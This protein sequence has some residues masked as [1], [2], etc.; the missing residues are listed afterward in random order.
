VIY[1]VSGIDTGVGKTVA[2]GLMLKYLLEHGQNA[3]A[4]KL[5]QTG[6]A[7]EQGDL[8]VY[9]SMTGLRDF[10]PCPARFDYPAAP[11]LAASLEGQSVDPGALVEAVDHAAGEYETLLVEGA[12]GLAVPLTP[13]QTFLDLLERTHWPVILVAS[14]GLGGLNHTLLSLETLAGRG[15]TLQGIV[16]NELPRVDSVMRSHAIETM[17]RGLRRHGFAERIV[18]MPALASGGDGYPESVAVDFSPLFG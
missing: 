11:D 13:E 12:G 18:T 9:A 16:F 2:T 8:P 5:V 17:G 15:L 1:F 6:L 4:I 3:S 7:D 14:A 10:P